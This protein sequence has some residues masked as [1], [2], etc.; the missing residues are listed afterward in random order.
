[1]AAGGTA[2]HVEPA[3]ATADS[4]SDLDPMT[5]IIFLAAGG[6]IENRLVPPRGYQLRT[7]PKAAIPRRISKDLLLLPI[8]LARAIIATRRAISGADVVVGFGGYLAGAAYLAAKSARIPIVVHEA[9]ARAGLANTLGSLFADE[10]ALADP[11]SKLR[12]GKLIGLPMRRS[13]LG[14]ATR[15]RRDPQGSGAEARLVLGLAPEKTTIVVMGGSQGSKR[16]NDALAEALDSLLTNDVQILHAL[17]PHNDLPSVRSGY[18]PTAYFDEIEL[19]YAAA[20]LLIARSGAAT[21]QEVAVFG[22]PTIFIPLPHGNGEQALNAAPLVDAGA[23]AMIQ[24]SEF[25]GDLLVR[26]IRR[27][28]DGPGVLAQMRRASTKLAHLD[29]ATDLAEIIARVAIPRA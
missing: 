25:N 8:Q 15:V 24:D 10:V 20:D 2:G 16:I 27:I 11:R 21:C 3:L 19:V 12:R 26:E 14:W 9:N 29:A 18:F 1:M 4:L 13:L 17:G 6:G 5:E 23:A 22:L 7:V 28:I